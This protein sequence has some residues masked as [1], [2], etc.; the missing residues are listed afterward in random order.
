MKQLY[1]MYADYG[2]NTIIWL[3]LDL[4]FHLWIIIFMFI[5][6]Y[7]AKDLPSIAWELFFTFSFLGISMYNFIMIILKIEDIYKVMVKPE[8]LNIKKK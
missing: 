8:L 3:I 2:K 7:F 1:E 6:I 5:V 4:I